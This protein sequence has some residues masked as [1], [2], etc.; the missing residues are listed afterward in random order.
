MMMIALLMTP[1]ISAMDEIKI[2][3]RIL[4][5][6]LL[7]T[8]H[9]RYHRSKAVQAM[10]MSIEYFQDIGAKVATN[11][12]FTFASNDK[13]RN[14]LRK[15][16]WKHINKTIPIKNNFRDLGTHLNFTNA[17]NGA[18]LTK[19]ME[20]GINMCTRLKWL[21]LSIQTRE[22]IVLTNILPAAMYGI[23]STRACKSTLEKLR[24]AIL[25]VIG[26]S[27]HKRSVDMSFEFVGTNKDLDPMSY[28]L[29]R[30]VLELRRNISKNPKR[31]GLVKLILKRNKNRNAGKTDETSQNQNNWRRCGE[32][33]ELH[34]YCLLY[35]SPSPRDS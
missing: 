15:L 35:T 12:C 10:E 11:K 33:K 20:A 1:W 6:D 28:M 34:I 9:G 8:A 13:T 23:E 19:R 17:H 25:G 32:E 24:S 21:G 7:V 5:D 2:M 29:T 26:P 16:C 22:K 31:E 18:T 4:A 3:P 30:R 27:S 14:Y